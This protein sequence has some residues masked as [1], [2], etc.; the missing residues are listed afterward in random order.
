MGK[1]I[2]VLVGTA[3]VSLGAMPLGQASG[4]AGTP[5]T[6][7]YDEVISP[8]VSSSPTSGTFTSNGETG[9]I[10]CNG[11]VNGRQPTGPGTFGVE[12]HYGNEGG[13]TCQSG[14]DV[15]GVIAFTIPTSTGGEQVTSHFTGRVGGL[16]DLFVARYEGDRMSGTSESV[17]RDGDC[18]SRPV[19][20][21]HTKGKGVL[22]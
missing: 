3:L 7:E 22:S 17:P 18:V 4:A 5:C 6:F 16:Q 11:P 12:G 1:R 20:K 21:V 10:T 9:A 14:G 8:G 19:T 2:L 13:V 15:D